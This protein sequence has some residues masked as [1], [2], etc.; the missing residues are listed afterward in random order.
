MYCFSRLSMHLQPA[1]PYWTV[2]DRNL[3]GDCFGILQVTTFHSGST[4]SFLSS[5]AGHWPQLPTSAVIAS[6]WRELVRARAPAPTAR[7]VA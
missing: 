1:L 2:G 6:T 7:M 5:A 3:H 4:T